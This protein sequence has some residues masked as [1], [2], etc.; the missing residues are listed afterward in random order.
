MNL[1]GAVS[2]RSCGVCFRL[3][4]GAGARGL[5]LYAAVEA[6]HLWASSLVAQSP[7]H[8]IHTLS[9]DGNMYEPTVLVKTRILMQ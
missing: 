5:S 4:P 3:Q 8:F 6:S 2:C 9:K 1:T 7:Q